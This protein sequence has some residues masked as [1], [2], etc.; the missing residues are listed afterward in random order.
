MSGV[1]L[2]LDRM[3]KDV[4][5]DE[6]MT[7]LPYRGGGRGCIHGTALSEIVTVPWHVNHGNQMLVVLPRNVS[8]GR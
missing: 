7:D 5:L 1:A 2:D 6:Q 8:N 3:E 4:C